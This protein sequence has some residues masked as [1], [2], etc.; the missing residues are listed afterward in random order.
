MAS[1][2]PPKKN[3]EF[4]FYVSLRDQSNTKLFKANPTLAA[5]DVKVSTDGGAEANIA[6]LPAV[7]PA[8]SRRVKVTLSASEMNGDNVQ[9]TFSDATGSEWCDLTVNIQTSVRQVDDLAFPTTSG[10]SIDVTAGGNVGLDWAN[11]ESPT[12]VVVLSGTTVKTATDVEADTADIQSRLPAA[13]SGGRMDSIVG[14]Y[15]SGQVPLQPTVAG[16]TLDVSAGGEAGMDWANIG[17]PTTV[18]VLSGTTIKTATDVETDTADIQS[19]L[20]AALAGGRMDASVGAYQSG[21]APLQPTV[22]GRTLDVNAAGEAGLDLDNTSGTLVKGTDITGFNDLS[23]AQV[24]AEADTALS[25]IHLDHLLATDYDPAN[26]PGVATALLNELV[27]S[28]GGVSRFTAN[29]LEQAPAGGA[30]SADWSAEEKQEIRYRLGLDGT[31]TVPTTSTGTLPAIQ[32]QADRI[33]TRPIIALDPV[34]DGRVV[35]HQGDS[36]THTAQGRALTFTQSAGGNWPDDLFTGGWTV[37]LKAVLNTSDVSGDALGPVA[38]TI[39][40]AN[41]VRFELDTTDTDGLAVGDKVYDLQVQAEKT[42][43]R[44]TLVSCKMTVKID[45]NAA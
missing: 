41:N 42:G 4:I 23:A 33:G 39:V 8:G 5:G 27:E 10:R 38:G 24:N 45:R 25:D 28:D 22:A 36:Y 32:T 14:A 12:T 13:L 11:I 37:T 44:A 20:P 43:E 16:R 29:T 2:V 40:D 17:S 34:L 3:A 19:R 21:L 9:V 18:V 15:A 31:Q 26:K 1:N 35:I 30:G 7:T 6:T